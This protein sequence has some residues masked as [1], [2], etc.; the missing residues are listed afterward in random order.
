MN[1]LVTPQKI[2]QAIKDWI[3]ETD[4]QTIERIFNENFDDKIIYDSKLGFFLVPEEEAKRL[5][6]KV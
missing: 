3:D 5:G 4:K 1:V 2:R 6:L